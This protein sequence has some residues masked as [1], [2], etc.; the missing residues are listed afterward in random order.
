MYAISNYT[1][2]KEVAGQ[3]F[4]F[5]PYHN[6]EGV[7]KIMGHL[8][9]VLDDYE[10]S[11]GNGAKDDRFKIL[12]FRDR[13]EILKWLWSVF[14]DIPEFTEL[15]ISRSNRDKGKK[16]DDPDH[17][18]ITFVTRYSGLK[19]ESR[20]YDFVDLHALID[21]ITHSIVN[22]VESKSCLLCKHEKR[23]ERNQPSRSIKCKTC[24]SNPKFT[25]NFEVNPK[26][27]RPNKTD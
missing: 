14:E 13:Q 5:H 7:D 21:M 12:T 16:I 23:D 4:Y 8:I 22:S 17:G 20:Y 3:L 2:I 15:N 11:Q 25:H 24:L 19:L 10:P 1:I 18:G 26:A 27:L 9:K 6:P